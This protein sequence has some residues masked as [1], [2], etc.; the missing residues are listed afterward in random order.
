MPNV[1]ELP[2]VNGTRFERKS[3]SAFERNATIRE[4]ENFVGF[5]GYKRIV[6]RFVDP[7]ADAIYARY[8]ICTDISSFL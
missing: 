5:Q 1:L 6:M 3:L 8:A 4:N 2:N 7:E